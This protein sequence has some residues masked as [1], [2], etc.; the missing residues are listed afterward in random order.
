MG[1]AGGTN[2]TDGTQPCG[3]HL[4][5]VYEEEEEEEKQARE[6]EGGRKGG[7]ESEASEVLDSFPG[8]ASN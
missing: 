1:S 2:R 7:R 8:L 4:L 3:G 6:R 5:P